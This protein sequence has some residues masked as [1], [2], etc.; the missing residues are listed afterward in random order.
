LKTELKFVSSKP[1][2]RGS[3]KLIYEADYEGKRVAVAHFLPLVNREDLKSIV[4]KEQRAFHLAGQHPNI[5]RLEGITQE[6]SWLVTE[7]CPLT[8]DKAVATFNLAQKV[9]R[10]IEV[11]RG[12]AFLHRLG[13]THGD[14]KPGNILIG[15][16]GNARLSDFGFAVSKAGARYTAPEFSADDVKSSKIDAKL[17][18]LYG[19]GGVLTFIFSG[20]EPWTGETNQF[21]LRKQIHPS[22]FLP[23]KE[24]DL[25]RQEH[26]EDPVIERI[27]VSIEKC[28]NPV[29]E[30]R[31]SV[32][33]VLFALEGI[34]EHLMRKSPDPAAIQSQEEQNASSAD[35]TFK[36]FKHL[37][38]REFQ[39][40]LLQ[41]Q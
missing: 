27:V 37:E 4:Q 38:A 36:I 19:L 23:T 22:N 34:F 35:I 1:I 30:E 11:C 26:K 41:S 9:S 40:N 13:I 20:Q 17:G 12:L 28:F 6:D 7:Y 2:G 39:L 32:R 24:L 3:L 8:L 33:S 31:G 14:L 15:E 29:P 16:E 10:A 25:I 5:V 21:I 18:D